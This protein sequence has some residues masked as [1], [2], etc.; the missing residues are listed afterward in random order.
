M[1]SINAKHLR[2]FLILSK[3]GNI[4]AAAKILYITPQGLSK[5]IGKMEA[6]LGVTLFYRTRQGMVL[7]EAGTLLQEKANLI[8]EELESIKTLRPTGS[9]PSSQE[10]QKKTTIYVDMTNGEIE[11]FGLDKVQAFMEQNPSIQV[12]V[13]EC[14]DQEIQKHVLD[15]STDIGLC[16]GPINNQLFRGHFLH[17][18]RHCL[19]INKDNPL[20]KRNSLTFKDLEGEELIFNSTAFSAYDNN[21]NRCLKNGF[22]PKIAFHSANLEN[23]HLMASRGMGVVISV[24]DVVEKSHLTEIFDNLVVV[25]FA[26]DED[27]F[28]DIFMILKRDGNIKPEVYL[29]EQ[30]IKKWAENL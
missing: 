5:T 28:I 4:A 22:I 30:F 2:E 6:D 19:V 29:L 13:N 23:A 25:P 14:S 15:G 24:E 8:I 10:G 27:C 7:T 11:Y 3:T 12:I 17:H 20:S 21:M 1:N 18:C 9:H 26:E 16:E